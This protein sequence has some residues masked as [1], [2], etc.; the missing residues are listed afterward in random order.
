MS[1]TNIERT[2][3][4]EVLC[5]DSVLRMTVPS[6]SCDP[7]IPG[8]TNS[9][10]LYMHFCRTV[11]DVSG[12]EVAHLHQRDS[13]LSLSSYSR[14]SVASRSLTPRVLEV[15]TVGT[16]TESCVSTSCTTDSPS[17]T[18]GGLE[19]VYHGTRP[20]PYSWVGSSVDLLKLGP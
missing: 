14:H 18:N 5:L 6:S 10:S 13:H 17:V 15:S 16:P 19:G 11:G 20:H 8:P 1:S 9:L 2:S 12:T 7:E 3:Q 4:S